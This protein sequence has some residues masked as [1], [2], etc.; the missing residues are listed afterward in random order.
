M[1]LRAWCRCCGGVV[2]DAGDVHV[3]LQPCGFGPSVDF[4]CPGCGRRGWLGLGLSAVEELV[5]HGALVIDPEPRVSGLS[6]QD[7]GE[8]RDLLVS[9]DWLDHV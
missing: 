6:P 8:L 4:L 5:P 1:E 9:E 7:A 3:H 2:V